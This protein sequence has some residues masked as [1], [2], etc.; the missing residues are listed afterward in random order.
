MTKITFTRSLDVNVSIT[1]NI[2]DGIDDADIDDLI[3]D[4]H[5]V[6][7]V[8]PHEPSNDPSIECV[9]CSVDGVDFFG[10]AQLI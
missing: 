9:E 10:S 8:E 4:F 3:D 5:F 6:V 2:P 1:L 7:S